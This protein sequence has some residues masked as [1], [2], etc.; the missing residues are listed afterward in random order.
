VR[1]AIFSDIHANLVALEAVM[2]DWREEVD[3]AWC[4]GDVVGYGPE[5]NACVELVR[6]AAAV[7]VAGNHDWAAVGRIDTADFN[8]LAATAADWTSRQLTPDAIEYLE[9]LPLRHQSGEFGLAHGSPRDPIWEY[10]VSA[11]TAAAN[12]LAYPGAAWFVGH[13]HVAGGYSL[14]E[15][16]SGT[17]EIRTESVVYGQWLPL[18]DRRHLINVGSVGQ[19]RDGDPAARYVILDVEERA[20][21]RRR[22][23]Y[24]FARTQ[25][26]MREV[27]LP[28]PLARRLARGR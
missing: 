15:T 7:C 16:D 19:P 18:G 21:H 4:L 28:E 5:P 20:Y 11:Q 24:N 3:L 8:E 25:A 13:S 10:V 22:V 1:I 12:M 14:G 6:S 2:A 9:N 27:G 17:L 26:R 23:R